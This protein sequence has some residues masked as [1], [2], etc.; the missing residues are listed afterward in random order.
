MTQIT[1]T[2]KATTDV[3]TKAPKGFIALNAPK[4][5]SVALACMAIAQIATQAVQAEGLTPFGHKMGCKGGVIDLTI[6]SGKVHSLE[7]FIDQLSNSGIKAVETDRKAY[8]LDTFR[9]VLAKRVTDHVSWCASTSNQ[10]HGGFGSRLAK[11]GLDS[12]RGEL[13]ELLNEL[14]SLL[15]KQFSKN[16]GT[17]YK[18]RKAA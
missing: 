10:T 6:L 4:P 9:A 12:R 8:P 18:A 17:I 1:V 13:A 2:T 7:S 15:A 14:S 5:N 3:M 16:Y 11:V